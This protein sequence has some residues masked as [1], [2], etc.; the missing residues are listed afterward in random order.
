MVVPALQDAW[1]SVAI[2]GIVRVNRNNRGAQSGVVKVTE[3]MGIIRHNTARFG[4][5]S[6]H[7]LYKVVLVKGCLFVGGM[8]P[9]RRFV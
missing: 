7:V 2:D 5:T 8:A 3:E 6:V 4:E 9:I 1:H